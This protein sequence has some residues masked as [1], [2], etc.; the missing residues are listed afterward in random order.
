MIKQAKRYM[1]CYIITYSCVYALI[2]YNTNILNWCTKKKISAIK[3]VDISFMIS[4][5]TNQ[6]TGILMWVQSDLQLDK[7]F[8][9]IL[10][11]TSFQAKGHCQGVLRPV[12]L[13]C[14]SLTLLPIIGWRHK[15]I[16]GT[17][18]R[19]QEN[20]DSKLSQQTDNLGLNPRK[21]IITRKNIKTY[22]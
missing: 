3:W 6:R 15:I 13:G 12:A 22:I 5:L 11:I 10:F 17:K 7:Q 14:P 1:A 16:A 20:H 9:L 4:L 2:F 8:V 19:S 21:W 18:L